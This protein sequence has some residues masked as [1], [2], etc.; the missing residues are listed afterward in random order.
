MLGC[1]KESST[2]EPVIFNVCI[3]CI[4][5]KAVKFK[6]STSISNGFSTEQTERPHQSPLKNV[7]K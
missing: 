3:N 5:A 1:I 4:L 2:F 6:K 7:K